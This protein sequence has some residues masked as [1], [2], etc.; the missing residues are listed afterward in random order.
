MATLAEQYAQLKQLLAEYTTLA[1]QVK[2]ERD[3][4]PPE[5]RVEADQELSFYDKTIAEIQG[6]LEE[7]K[8]YVG[9]GNLGSVALT[10][11]VLGTILA[12]LADAIKHVSDRIFEL[13]KIR[14]GY[15]FV[16]DQ[17]NRGIS[18][19]QIQDTLKALEE[20]ASPVEARHAREWGYALGA[21]FALA[22]AW[23]VKK[24]F[25]ERRGTEA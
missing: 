6:I 21:A 2:S 3:G 13:R 25:F 5:L 10:A 9:E 4:Y 14:E 12:I 22:V 24:T 20:P 15:A 7:V 23:L 17:E 1:T 16:Q 18:Q 11:A 19:E 8:N